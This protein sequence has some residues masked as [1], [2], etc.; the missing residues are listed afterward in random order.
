MFTKF[1][2]TFDSHEEIIYIK[3]QSDSPAKQENIGIM[4]RRPSLQCW[5]A[6]SI[7]CKALNTSPVVSYLYYSGL[8]DRL[9]M[10]KSPSRGIFFT[11]LNK[12]MYPASSLAIMYNPNKVFI[13]HERNVWGKNKPF[14]YV[15]MAMTIWAGTDM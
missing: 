12:N 3:S 10:S 6:L 2:C 13:M 11:K 8:L 7:P 9:R 1:P 14:L 5:K 4:L 15:Y